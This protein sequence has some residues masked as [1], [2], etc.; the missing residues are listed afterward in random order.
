MLLQNLRP[1]HCNLAS[2]QRALF[3]ANL[4]VE[5]TPGL[6]RAEATRPLPAAF[7]GRRLEEE[8]LTFQRGGMSVP[9]IIVFVAQ[10]LSMS[11]WTPPKPRTPL[12]CNYPGCSSR[13]RCSNSLFP[14][15][16]GKIAKE[17]P[18]IHIQK[19]KRC[20]SREVSCC[21]VAG[22]STLRTGS[23]LES[24]AATNKG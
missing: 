18:T 21:G 14:G 8:R 12:Q 9:R 6:E 20:T 15:A 7:L 1:P 13:P 10:P 23:L 16:A 4:L 2:S 19:S 11:P 3:R 22:S 24:F 5:R 17:E